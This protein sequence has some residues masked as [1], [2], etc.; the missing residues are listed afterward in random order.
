MKVLLLLALAAS[1][2]SDAYLTNRNVNY[3]H[4]VERNFVARPFVHGQ[5][6][7][8]G[9]S[10]GGFALTLVADHQLRKHHRE[11]AADFVT[12]AS[13]IGHTAGALTSLK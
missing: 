4:G 13:I 11:R 2:G 9:A 3:R 6:W 5:G 1:H 7:L 10:A 8:I 12:G